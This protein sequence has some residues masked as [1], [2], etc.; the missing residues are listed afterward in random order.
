M[1]HAAIGW[2]LLL[3]ALPA[4]AAPL[5]IEGVAAYVNDGTI[6]VGEV[7]EMIAPALGELQKTYQGEEL[8]A[9]VRELYQEALEELIATRLILKAYGADTKINKA[10]VEKHVEAR[11]SEFIQERFGGDRQEFLKA[12]QEE[13]MPLEEW[14]RRLRE[15]VIV[16]LMRNRDVDSH[17]V[18]SPRE[19]R[20]VYERN[21]AEY[22]RPERVRL[23]VIRIHGGT[24]GTHRAVREGLAGSVAQK[25]A[26]GADFGELARQFSEDPSSAKGGEWGWFALPDL[27]SE[28]AQVVARLERGTSSGVITMD[29]DF[30]LARVEE[31]EAA[32]VV[33]FDDVRASIEKDLR[34]K[35]SRRLYKLW[36][37]SLRKDAY[38]EV[39][40]SVV[41]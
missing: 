32:G 16:G 20:A 4:F 31:R 28:M 18:I 7:K 12:L 3:I 14:Q 15:R 27:R 9:K 33:P 10:A 38:I 26:A 21:R 5:T 30:Y 6:T 25:L 34:R 8:K 40:D 1:R 39:V 36:I 37:Q 19:V 17:V 11:V 29:G 35:E 2:I 24:N 13:R 22:L 23:R 41:P